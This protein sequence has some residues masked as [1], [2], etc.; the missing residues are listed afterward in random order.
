MENLNQGTKEWLEFRKKHIGSSD[1][2]VIM[3]ASPWKD[4]YT[5][6]LEKTGR[7]EEGFAT[8]A[9]RRGKMLEPVARE[10]YI[11]ETGVDVIPFVVE[12]KKWPV[13]LASLDGI[14]FDGTLIVEIKCPT[15]SKTLDM[16]RNKDLE[17]HYLYQV[18]WQ[19]MI[20]E[21]KSCDFV[22]YMEDGFT[23]FTI[24]SLP[25]MQ[26]EMLEKAKEFWEFVEKG[27]EPPKKTDR[28]EEINEMEFW[29]KSMAFNEI[30]K[31]KAIIEAKYEKAKAALLQ[32]ANGRQ[33]KNDFVRI[34]YTAPSKIVDWSKVKKHYNLT[35]D[36]LN[37]FKKDKKGYWTVTLVNKDNNNGCEVIEINT[38]A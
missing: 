3:G 32:E 37:P 33:C 19:L 12:S 38:G 28:Y 30:A 14:S 36:I 1:I 27:V 7:K 34:V 23:Y 31:E 15:S 20:S 5:L 26:K 10:M 22:V 8:Q 21:A 29:D 18:Q 25:D 17:E 13:A 16:A 6:W 35:D 11:K 4:A 2:G 24:C 9:M